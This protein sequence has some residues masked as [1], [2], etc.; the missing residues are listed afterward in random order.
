MVCL[1]S[2]APD[3]KTYLAR[4]DFGRELSEGA[5]DALLKMPKGFDVVFVLCDGLSADAVM[6]HATTLLDEMLPSLLRDG[7]SIG[8]VAIVE[9]GRVAIGDEIGQLLQASLIV[10]L[11][12]ER[13]GLTSPKKSWSLS[14]LDAREL[15]GATQSG[16]ACQTSAPRACRIEKQRID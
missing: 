2:K 13:P 5:K 9:Q 3:R 16:I 1:S 4:P 14:D 6:Q 7:W 8:P 11:I 12:G 15:G 10:V